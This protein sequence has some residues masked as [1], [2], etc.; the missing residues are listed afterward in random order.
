MF[1]TERERM[2]LLGGS[3]ERDSAGERYGMSGTGITCAVLSEPVLLPDVQ[4]YPRLCC[5]TMCSTILDYDATR[6]AVLRQAMLLPG[7]VEPTGGHRARAPRNGGQTGTAIAY[8][9]RCTAYA[10]RCP[11]VWERR[12]VT[13]ALSLRACYAMSGTDIAYATISLCAC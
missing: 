1:G 4:Y 10:A 12:Q 8:G 11:R 5:Y 6:H 2:G 13:P 9:A 7:R 3:V